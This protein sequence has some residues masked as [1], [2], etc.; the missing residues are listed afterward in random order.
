MIRLSNAATLYHADCRETLR[1]LP[2]DSID[3]VCTDPP[4]GIDFMAKDWDSFGREREYQ[5]RGGYENKGILPGYGRGGTPQ[6]R[7]LY[8]QKSA[9]NFRPTLKEACAASLASYG[10]PPPPY[11]ATR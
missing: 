2:S 5:E 4:Y 7:N 9:I 3:S 8:Q 10:L 6:Q 1:A 11:G